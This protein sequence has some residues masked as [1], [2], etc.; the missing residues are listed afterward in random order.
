MP[1]RPTVRYLGVDT[2]GTFTDLVEIDGAGRLRFDKAFS[3]PQAPEKGI[4]DALAALAQQAKLDLGVLLAETARFAHGTTVSTNA[5]IQ[6]R[7]AR[8][9]LIATRGFED[10]LIIGRGP[11]GR[12]GGL[13]Q[14]KAMDFLH[15]EPPPPL[16]PKALAHGI[17]GGY[18]GAGSQVRLLRG[19]E[20]WKKL[21]AG[22]IPREDADFGG[23]VE[24]LPSKASDVLKTGDVL[25]FFA[26]GGGG[27]GDPL[28]REPERV[29]NDVANRWVS[30]AHARANYGV[31][32]TEDGQA[33]DAETQALRE[34]IRGAR[35][36]RPTAPWVSEDHCQHPHPGRH[37]P[38]RVG[39]NVDL[40]PDGVLSCR[41][42]GDTLSGPQGRAAIATRPLK[43]AG[44][45]MALRHGGDGPNFVLEEISCPSCATLVAVREIRLNGGQTKGG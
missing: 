28:D 31:A 43:A 40:A 34:N 21:E 14:S 22:Q 37:E 24:H 2:G 20:A 35:K 13:P 7:G 30:R 45:W 4:L 23:A 3:T 38:W 6:R 41:R 12:A 1:E 42:C 19:T 10:T 17:D 32:L 8:V 25:V 44:P 27:F 11:V 18:P 33:H 9:G 5:L 26:P 16:V 29:A 39:E 36:Q 15:T